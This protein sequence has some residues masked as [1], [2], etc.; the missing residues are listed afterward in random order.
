MRALRAIKRVRF[1]VRQDPD[2]RRHTGS[3]VVRSISTPSS[4]TAV[5]RTKKKGFRQGRAS[6]CDGNI[7]AQHGAR[8]F[9]ASRDVCCFAVFFSSAAGVCERP[10]HRAKEAASQQRTSWRAVAS[11]NVR[12]A[13]FVPLTKHTKKSTCKGRRGAT[14]DAASTY[15][16]GSSL[17]AVSG[18]RV[19]TFLFSSCLTTSLLTQVVHRVSIPRWSQYDAPAAA[20]QARE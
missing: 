6:D 4:A 3:R 7:A 2:A 14:F 5:S 17:A 1:S 19:R 13:A 18:V 8:S 15:E 20:T 16:D 10:A 9:G 12:N 11:G